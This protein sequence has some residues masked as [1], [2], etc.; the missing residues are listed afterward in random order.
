MRL[1]IWAGI[2][3]VVSG[4]AGCGISLY[5]AVAE[6]ADLVDF[7]WW[8]SLPFN[9]SWALLALVA[10]LAAVESAIW[11]WRHAAP[12]RRKRG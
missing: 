3:L 10:M 9:A 4:I 2:A 1:A 6:R 12:R 5:G 7:G 11:E 8:L